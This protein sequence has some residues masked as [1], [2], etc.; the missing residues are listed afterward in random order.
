MVDVPTRDV[1]PAFSNDQFA[2]EPPGVAH[3]GIPPPEIVL[4]L[5]VGTFRLARIAGGAAQSLQPRPASNNPF[6]VALHVG[7]VEVSIAPVAR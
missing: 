4:E 7:L 3:D 2:P 5:T 1:P 6:T